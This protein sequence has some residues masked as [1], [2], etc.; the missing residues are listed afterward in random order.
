MTHFVLVP[1]AGGAGWYWSRVVPLL[2]SAGHTTTA[3]ELPADDPGKGLPEY[4]ALVADA[5][6]APGASVV[7]AQSLGGFSAAAATAHTRP[8][9]LV[10]LNAMIPVPGETSGEWWQAVG[11]GAAMLEAARAGGWSTEFD[12]DTYF[13]HD[14]DPAL[15]AEGEPHQRPEHDV[16]FEAPCEFAWPDVPIK[17]LA[18]ADDRFFPVDFQRRVARDR[19]GLDVEVLPGGHLAALSQPEAVATAL[20]SDPRLTAVTS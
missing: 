18:G 14:I 3:I 20:L 12:L 1:G 4:A 11:Q 5:M 2:E 19:L 15:A 9:A 17:V 8:K 6:G 16:V 7:V 10:F 13:L